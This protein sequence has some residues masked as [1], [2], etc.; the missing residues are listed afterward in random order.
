MERISEA[1]RFA[2]KLGLPFHLLGGG[3][4]SVLPP[5]L[6]AVV[7]I[8][9]MAGRSIE[10][11][12]E[13]IRLTS[14]AGETWDNLVGWSVLQGIGGLENLAGIPGTVGAAPIQNI[15]AYGREISNVFESLTALDTE[16]GE[17]R[18]FSSEECGFD[19]RH[20]RFKEQPSRHLVT[21]VTLLLPYEWQPC[22]EYDGL[23]NLPGIVTPE[24]VRTA[25]LARRR[26]RLPDWRLTGNAGSF[27]QNP[28]VSEE[29]ARSIP[30]VP[31]R[32]V[33]G[34]IKISAGW[35]LEQCGLKGHRHGGAGF[36]EQHALVLVN[37]GGATLDDVLHLADQARSEVRRRFGIDLA[38]EPVVI[39]DS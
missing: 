15:G 1:I 9:A 19:Y 33:H 32:A 20:S 31:G 35:L 25:V 2:E 8:S 17:T 37:N 34:G 27:F 36:S 16:T 28:I 23:D 6:E 5:R 12:R 24:D 11:V 10:Q 3:S 13:G 39:A 30:E 38:Q 26:S 7:G 18:T 29:V 21:E 22:L 14:A 4:N